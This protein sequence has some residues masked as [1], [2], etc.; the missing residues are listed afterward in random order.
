MIEKYIIDQT[1]YTGRCPECN[2]DWDLGEA[3]D[4]WL[5]NNATSVPQDIARLLAENDSR[6]RGWTPENKLHV[7][8]LLTIEN[9]DNMIFDT[10]KHYQCPVCEI[11]WHSE[12]G[13]R[14]DI[15][16][17][18]EYTKMTEAERKL[19]FQKFLFSTASDS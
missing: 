17:V 14:T 18:P 5:K 9:S 1:N 19:F 6:L 7:S 4:V 15:Y 8:N 10:T 16:K 12:T 11:A 3:P 2:A 13:Q